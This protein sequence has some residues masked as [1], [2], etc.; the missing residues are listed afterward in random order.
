M[1]TSS[2]NAD[3]QLSARSIANAIGSAIAVATCV[4]IACSD[5][6]T[7][8]GPA[9]SAEL[10]ASLIAAIREH[11]GEDAA[12][13]LRTG[14]DPNSLDA[15]THDGDTALIAATRHADGALVEMLLSSG[16]DVNLRQHANWSDLTPLMI[17]AAGGHT[18]VAHQLL[19][20]GANVNAR[21]GVDGAGP[22]ALFWAGSNGHVGVV[23]RLLASGATI[24]PRDLL[25]AISAGQV[26]VV[27]RLLKAGA[28]PRALLPTGRSPRDE[29]TLLSGDNGAK[30]MS[31]IQGYLHAP[32]RP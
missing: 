1:R 5:V 22:T 29:A 28:D 20:A 30:M 19:T 10:N 13:L 26:E 25:A 31:L 18:A 27:D 23:A 14:A 2:M 6:K 15:S 21:S 16:A 12:R 9:I 4:L 24:A 11:R 17:A 7:P 32:E 8:R 3:V